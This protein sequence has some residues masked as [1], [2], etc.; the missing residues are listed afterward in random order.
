MQP[1]LST[2]K[3]L[4][5]LLAIGLQQISTDPQPTYPSLILLQYFQANSWVSLIAPLRF[6]LLQRLCACGNEEC[7]N[8]RKL[9]LAWLSLAWLEQNSLLYH[10]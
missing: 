2:V 1:Q 5:E 10:L 9:S 3:N 8:R 6:Y 4:W 7:L